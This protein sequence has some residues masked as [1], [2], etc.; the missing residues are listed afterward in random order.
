MVSLADLYKAE[1]KE[2]D[3]LIKKFIE[4]NSYPMPK[5]K[6]EKMY[7]GYIDIKFN[8]SLLRDLYKIYFSI[9]NSK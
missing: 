2:E 4:E 7:I 9:Y 1:G 5:R 8:E 6:M 3:E